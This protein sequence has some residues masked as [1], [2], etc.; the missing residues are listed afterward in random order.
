LFLL[1]ISVMFF[2]PLTEKKFREM[3]GDVAAR[4]AEE[5]LKIHEEPPWWE[6]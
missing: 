4:R 6:S 2:Y 5:K 3:V 1:A